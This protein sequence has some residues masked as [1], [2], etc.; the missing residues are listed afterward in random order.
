MR[1]DVV[2]VGG[3]LAGSAAAIGLARAGI[4]T[5]VLEKRPFPRDKPCGE[6]LLPEGVARLAALGLSGAPA[7]AGG[8]PFRGII[9]RHGPVEAR[10]DFERGA[11]GYGVRRL[12]LDAVVQQAARAAGATFIEE[13]AR[14]L[15]VDDG[16]RA[17]GRDGAPETVRVATVAGREIAARAVIGADGPQSF[18][19]HAAGLDGG[20]PRDGRYGLRRHFRL[21]AGVPLPERVEVSYHDGYELYLTPAAPGVVGIAALCEREVLR[22]A[23]GSKAERLAALLEGAPAAVRERLAGAAPESDPLACGPLRV[24]AKR[25]VRGPVLLIGDAAGYV[26]AITGEGMS[27][28]LGS[29]ALAVDAIFAWLRGGTPREAAFAEYARRRAALFRD[30]ALLTHAVV[31]FARRPALGRLAVRALAAE[32]ALFARLLSVGH[33]EIGIA[34]GLASFA[35]DRLR[36]L[37]TSRA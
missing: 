8:Q 37:A 19:R 28:A 27:L 23:E 34:G 3:G 11:C 13:A 30:H 24:R 1:A 15:A 6:G 35:W 18:V 20:P 17:S 22:A 7:R 2:I 36:G 4:E 5:V 10:G 25:V 9:Y 26:D 12:L 16:P 33:G 14:H 21:A 31:F 32:P 29:S